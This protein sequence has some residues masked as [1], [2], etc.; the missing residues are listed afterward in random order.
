MHQTDKEILH[1][2]HHDIIS[3]ETLTDEQFKRK[4]LLTHDSE[5][6]YFDQNHYDLV[7]K[8]KDSN[9]RKGITPERIKYFT[10]LEDGEE[11]LYF[12]EGSRH[13]PA[14]TSTGQTIYVSKTARMLYVKLIPSSNPTSSLHNTITNIVSADNH[15]DHSSSYPHQGREG[16]GG[17]DQIQQFRDTQKVNLTNKQIFANDSHGRLYA[18]VERLLWKKGVIFLPKYYK[19]LLS[20]TASTKEC[21][22][23]IETFLMTIA[24]YS[25]YSIQSGVK[26]H[27]FPDDPESFKKWNKELQTLTTNSKVEQI[28]FDV[29][30][31]VVMCCTLKRIKALPEEYSERIKKQLERDHQSNQVFENRIDDAI[32]MQHKAQ[33][34]TGM[35][36]AMI[37]E[38]KKRGEDVTKFSTD[39][40][41]NYGNLDYKGK[42]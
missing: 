17:K 35:T 26:D 27:D 28:T 8:T 12:M 14:Y 25:D 22:E 33:E 13:I 2:H 4:Y 19:Y 23:N 37:E 41:L 38:A 15:D 6:I 21:L 20:Q 32:S 34:V 11:V 39:P 30:K 3:S 10:R 9:K 42:K 31:Y 36:Q 24:F 40:L 1:Q 7:A 5:C 18:E 29:I 16:G